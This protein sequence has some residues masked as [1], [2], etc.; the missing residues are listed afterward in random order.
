[1]TVAPDTTGFLTLVD[2]PLGVGH[3]D[4]SP[5]AA[6][7]LV[8]SRTPVVGQHSMERD[9]YVGRLRDMHR[10]G[11]LVP[12]RDER[13]L[14]HDVIYDELC[15]GVI[16]DASRQAYRAVI[17][18][19]VDRGAEG[20]LLGCTEIGLLIGAD[21]VDVPVFDTTIEEIADEA[22]LSN[23]AIYYNFAGKEKLFL[24]LLDARLDERLEHTRQTLAVGSGSAG[25]KRD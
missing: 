18:N 22:R 16:N 19:L 9:F 12:D 3:N 24:A 17:T 7:P 6:P 23:G 13:R 25:E 10:L 8:V 11:V 14:V 15:V 21:D 5:T 1:M 20:I 2:T 4:G